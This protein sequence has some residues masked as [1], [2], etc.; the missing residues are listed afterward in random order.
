MVQFLTTFA[1]ACEKNFL[2]LKPW[3]AYL[4][5]GPAPDCIVNFDLQKNAK[6]A[7]HLNDIWLIALAILDDLLR[8]AG[9]VA[10]GFV[11]YGGIRFMV[12]RGQPDNTKAAIG[13]ITN[14]LIGLAIAMIG[15]AV[16]GFIGRKLGN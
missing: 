8:I 15:A 12:S 13:T 1:S 9:L 11:I 10:V 7:I 6:E 16:V 4:E 2:G 14:A 5:K 3:H